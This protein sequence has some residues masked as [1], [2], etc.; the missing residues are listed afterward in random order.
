MKILEEQRDALLQEMEALRNK[1][2]GLEMAMSLIS[3]DGAPA[4][5]GGRASR[6]SVKGA[7]LDLLRQSGTTGLTAQGTVDIAQARGIKLDLG[8]VR[9]LLSRFKREELAVF[10]GERY[11]LKQFAHAT[12][13][14]Q[15]PQFVAVK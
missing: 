11:K 4:T 10:D 3:S 7:V 9:S 8:S 5:Q 12:E 2:A 1:I 14:P 6:G 13:R 15:P